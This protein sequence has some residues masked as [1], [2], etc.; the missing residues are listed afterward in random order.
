MPSPAVEE[1][2]VGTTIYSKG[3]RA[4]FSI[5]YSLSSSNPASAHCSTSGLGPDTQSRGRG[6]FLF[7]L[8]AGVGV[9]AA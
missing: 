1:Y 3:P 9:G 5:P 4:L 7:F 2:A 6:E 8:Q